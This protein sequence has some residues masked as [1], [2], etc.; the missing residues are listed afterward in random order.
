MLSSATQLLR[1]VIQGDSK[2]GVDALKDVGTQAGRTDAQMT[3]WGQSMNSAANY[4][5][6]G[7]GVLAGV[8]AKS[9]Q[10]TIAYGES[11]DS[12]TDITNLS[13]ESASRLVGQWQGFGVSADKGASAVKFFEKNLDAARQ[14]SDEMVE[15]FGRL[16]ISL[17]DIQTLS[18]EDLLAKT[19]D[20]LA[21]TE[22]TGARAAIALKLLGRSA[23]ELADWYNAAPEDIRRVNEQLEKMGLVWG[24]KELKTWQDVIDAQREMK[25]AW[26][27]VQIA[28]AQYVL[29][30]LPPVIEAFGRLLE[31]LKPLAP[32]LVPAT[33]ALGTFVAIVK[34]AMIVK[35]VTMA[36]K[37][38]YIALGGGQL[39]TTAI[40]GFRT[41]TAG[42]GLLGTTAGVSAGMVGLLTGA[43]TLSTAAVIG[44][45]WAWNEWRDAVDQANQAHQDYLD[46]YDKARAR[47]VEKYGEGSEQVNKYDSSLGPKKEA[48][49]SEPWW[50]PF[51]WF[52]NGGDFMT[53]GPVVFGAGEAGPERVTITPLN[54]SRSAGGSGMTMELHFHGPIMGGRAGVREFM[55]LAGEEAELA[56]GGLV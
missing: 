53:N 18:D 20:G 50:N 42:I 21:G 49:Y 40:N 13:A 9:T 15:T 51:G 4:A 27:G 11:I 46:N 52:A 31:I 30:Y 16:G 45:I 8:I 22:D 54:G 48:Q 6:V 26:M 19:R 32:V 35:E 7:V 56:M 17:S 23:T 41:L 44:A 55:K 3:K 10:T 1:L 25:I 28:I 38:L 39:I 37:G 2:G 34:T 12:V 14:G 47:I 5:A 29:P 33:F 43:V 36:V 24:D